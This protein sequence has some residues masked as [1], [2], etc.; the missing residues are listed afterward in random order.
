MNNDVAPTH[1]DK[2]WIEAAGTRPY[3]VTTS[4]L[5][6]ERHIPGRSPRQFALEY[7]ALYDH[8]Q[9]PPGSPLELKVKALGFE[10]LSASIAGPRVRQLPDRYPIRPLATNRPSP[11]E[12]KWRLLHIL[13]PDAQRGHR[14]ATVVIRTLS[15]RRA[16]RR[17]VS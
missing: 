2:V 10:T 5:K 12:R 3:S 6:G 17:G 4:L 16:L 15:P 1:L 14:R 13:H 9:A 8:G 11:R 7:R